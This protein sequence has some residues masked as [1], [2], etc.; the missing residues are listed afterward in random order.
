LAV[1]AGSRLTRFAV[2]ACGLGRCRDAPMRPGVPGHR[3]CGRGGWSGVSGDQREL[4]G[5]SPGWT[6]GWSFGWSF[7]SVRVE[8]GW[9]WGRFGLVGPVGCDAL[10]GGGEGDGGVDVVVVVADGEGAVVV[11]FEG[12]AEVVD[13]VMMPRAERDQ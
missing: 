12:P 13:D 1:G 2:L 6:F 4:V 8:R 9:W 10:G 11:E 7:V 3:G 5:W